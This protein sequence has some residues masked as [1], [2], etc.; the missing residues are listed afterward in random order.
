METLWIYMRVYATPVTKY[1][2]WQGN[3]DYMRVYGTIVTM[4]YDEIFMSNLRV[5]G[6]FVTKSARSRNRCD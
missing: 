1:A 2:F 5:L 6:A 3:C 4:R